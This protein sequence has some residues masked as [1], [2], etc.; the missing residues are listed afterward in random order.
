MGSELDQDTVN[1]KTPDG[2]VEEN[3]NV[4]KF[5]PSLERIIQEKRLTPEGAEADTRPASTVADVL[6]LKT[7]AD[8]DEPRNTI[9]ALADQ[10]EDIKKTDGLK[11]FPSKSLPSTEIKG[12]ETW[13]GQGSPRNSKTMI[14]PKRRHEVEVD[15]STKKPEGKEMPEA[16]G[17]PSVLES[18]LPE[19]RGQEKKS[20]KKMPNSSTLGCKEVS[21][22]KQEPVGTA[23]STA[24][25]AKG[26]KPY[27]MFG[28]SR[29]VHDTLDDIVQRM[30]SSADEPT[31]VEVSRPTGRGSFE[32]IK[33]ISEKRLD[34]P[35]RFA[36]ERRLSGRKVS[37]TVIETMSFM[38]QTVSSSD[39]RS[40]RGSSERKF[41][42]S[43]IQGVCG[44][45]Y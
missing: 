15:C 43:D 20:D 6:E 24:G 26:Y 5:V 13:T 23:R 39:D 44:E 42:G 9:P 7:S 37:N 29:S 8:L 27:R 28:I 22:A 35:G 40:P 18:V 2:D 1:K 17:A 31:V 14:A 30:L 19:K 3:R 33:R 34:E 36:R 32:E 45:C 16:H 12:E 25:D 41:S 10:T 21:Q 11:S 38:L 4:K